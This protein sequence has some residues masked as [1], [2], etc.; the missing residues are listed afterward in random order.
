MERASPLD[1]AQREILSTT[2]AAKRKLRVGGFIALSNVV[3]LGLCALFSIAFASLDPGLLPIGLVLV[4]LAWNEWRGRAL[5]LDGE[6]SAPRRLALNQLAL[7]VAVLF[8]CAHSAYAAWTSPG[9]LDVMAGADPELREVLGGGQ[10]PF[11]S[12]T[13]SDD[14]GEWARTATVVVYGAIAAGSSVVQGLTAAYYWSMRGAV[15][16]YAAAPAWARELA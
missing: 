8:Y 7:L 12:E 1:D 6:G 11:G 9:L 10:F 3:G 13:G 2:K 14:L 16:T 4:A 5:L 15:A